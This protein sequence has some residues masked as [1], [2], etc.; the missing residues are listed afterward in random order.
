MN[1][2]L[3]PGLLGS[4]QALARHPCR[5]PLRRALPPATR[6]LIQVPASSTKLVPILNPRSFPPGLLLLL[7]V[8]ISEMLAQNGHHQ[9][10]QPVVLRQRQRPLRPPRFQPRSPQHQPR[11]P[12]QQPHLTAGLIHSAPSLPPDTTYHTT[13]WQLRP[14][15]RRKHSN[16]HRRRKPKSTSS[17]PRPTDPS[18]PPTSPTSPACPYPNLRLRT[19][20]RRQPLRRHHRRCHP[21]CDP[22]PQTSHAP[23]SHF[24]RSKHTIPPSPPRPRQH[25]LHR[26]LTACSKPPSL[27]SPTPSTK[28]KPPRR[29]HLHL[30]IHIRPIQ[31]PTPHS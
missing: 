18:P 16:R 31:T 20:A 14:K 23:L 28:E 6:A 13:E 12:Q 9:I 24:P 10:Q 4:F 5:G 25:H 26:P 27:T 17:K 30:R 22:L 29:L 11:P 3:N 8:Q 21:T 2:P 15:C 19:R 1:I 7:R